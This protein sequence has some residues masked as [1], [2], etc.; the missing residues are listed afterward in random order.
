MKKTK[1]PIKFRKNK[2]LED[3]AMH[4]SLRALRKVA[5]LWVNA[6]VL[7][8]LDRSNVFEVGLHCGGKLMKAWMEETGKYISPPEDMGIYS[9]DRYTQ[10]GLARFGYETF[11]FVGRASE[12]IEALKKVMP[13]CM[14]SR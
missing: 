1:N 14:Q 6:E 8:S 5:T 9:V 10:P 12:I 2:T 13:K 3:L 4:P 7:F 11:Y